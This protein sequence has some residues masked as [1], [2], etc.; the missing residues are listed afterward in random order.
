MEEHVRSVLSL[1]IPQ[2]TMVAQ[3][4]SVGWPVLLFEADSFQSISKSDPDRLI[5]SHGLK[6][7]PVGNQCC[8]SCTPTSCQPSGANMPVTTGRMAKVIT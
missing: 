8:L 7:L 1:Q 5:K 2:S 3:P 4:L 6:L